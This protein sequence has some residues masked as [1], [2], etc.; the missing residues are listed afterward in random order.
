MDDGS[1]GASGI[2]GED[3]RCINGFGGETCKKQTNW[4]T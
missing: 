1:G 4:K 3:L 2:Y